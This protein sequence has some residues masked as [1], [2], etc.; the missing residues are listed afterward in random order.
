MLEVRQYCAARLAAFKIP[1]SVIFLDAIPMTA[2]G[3]TDRLAL[4]ALVRER[5]PG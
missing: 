3:K 2:R 4:D 1:R 5:L